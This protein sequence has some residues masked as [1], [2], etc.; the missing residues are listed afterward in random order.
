MKNVSATF[1][2]GEMPFAMRFMEMPESGHQL[3]S[4]MATNSGVYTTNCGV[5]NNSPD[6]GEILKK[7]D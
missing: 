6:D 7:D 5:N 4:S 2:H 1:E 3:P